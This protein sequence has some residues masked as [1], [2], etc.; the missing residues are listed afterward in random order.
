VKGFATA[1]AIAASLLACAPVAD[2]AGRRVPRG[3]YGVMY[4]RAITDAPDAMQDAQWARM[5]RSG[6]ESVRAV[7]LW[8]QAQPDPGVPPSFT[9]TDRLVS[10]AARHRIL[11]LPVVRST[12]VWAAAD[13]SKIGSPPAHTSDYTAYLQALIERYGP[14]GSF[15][16]AHPEIPRRPLREW[17]V[18][19]EPHLNVW[20]NTDGRS[21]DAWAP[22]YAQLLK[23][24]YV[25]IKRLDPG[26]TVVLAGLADYAWKHLDLLNRSRIR[27][28]FDVASFNFF[29][30]RPA[31]VVRGVRYFR[32]AMAR[33]GERRKP[34]WLTEATWPAGQHRV[35]VPKVAWQRAWY[36]T[37]AGMAKRLTGLYAVA[38]ANRRK[39]R[40]GRVYWYTWASAY[41]DGDLFDYAGLNRFADGVAAPQ[42]A[43]RAYARSA[44]RYEGCR[45]TSAGACRR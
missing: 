17:Q 40:L 15:W 13:P 41:G 6:V 22:E 5:A 25:T 43:L 45:K 16:P 31:L 14:R 42:P 11:L 23:Q 18:W 9:Y 1:I 37:D 20:W 27:R 28:Y 35:P 10:L 38:A 8:N 44:R 3:F 24:S 19:N 7:F 26:A 2:A 34:V 21:P 29:T 30:S 12:P 36:T 33:G 32:R 4:D 39:A